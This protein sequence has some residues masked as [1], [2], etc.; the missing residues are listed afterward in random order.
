LK[1]K[2]TDNLMSAVGADTLQIGHCPLGRGGHVSTST[3]NAEEALLAPVGSPRV[4][5]N[6]V[7]SAVLSTPAIELDGMVVGQVAGL[8]SIYDNSK[9]LIKEYGR[10]MCFL[11]C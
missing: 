3:H 1:N 2:L 6:P 4:S 11:S 8:A 5:A 7:V 10:R 9:M